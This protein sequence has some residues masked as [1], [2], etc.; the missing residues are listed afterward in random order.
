MTKITKFPVRLREALYLR[1]KTQLQLGIELGLSES[2]MS[3][4]VNGQRYPSLGM[5]VDIAIT[6][7]VTTDYLLGLGSL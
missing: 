1:N 3:R 5:L 4:L 6:L 2:Y 7:N